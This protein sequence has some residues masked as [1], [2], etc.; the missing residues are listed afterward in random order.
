MRNGA[1]RAVLDNKGPPRK[2]EG[3]GRDAG[4]RNPARGVDPKAGGSAQLDGGIIK[5]NELIKAL[6]NIEEQQKQQ[7]IIAELQE[8]KISFWKV[9]LTIRSRKRRSDPAMGL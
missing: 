3:S 9:S 6:R 4:G 2:T 7:D 8:T 1:V 5:L